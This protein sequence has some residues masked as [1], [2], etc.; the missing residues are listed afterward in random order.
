M[1]SGSKWLL[2][3]A[4]KEKF[5]A[6]LTP[7]LPVLRAQAGISQEELAN[8]IG[9][10]RQ[11]YSSVERKVRNMSWNTYLSLVLFF[12]QNKKTHTMFRM[13][14]LFPKELA[15]CFNNERADGE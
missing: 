4:D 1:E 5:I 10:S 15:A 13:L 6:A 3:D 14:S 9:V 2:A 12:D 11:T 8:L 7:N